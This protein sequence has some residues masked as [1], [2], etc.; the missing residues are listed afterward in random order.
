MSIYKVD[1]RTNRNRSH[2]FAFC[3]GKRAAH[4][5]LTTAWVKATDD[6]DPIS[7]E[8]SLITV[9]KVKPTEA[10]ILG[11]LNTY[12]S[13]SSNSTLDYETGN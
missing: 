6:P 10:G 7:L 3:K 8:N 12:A 2:S 5:A 4:V 9:V 1:I 13:H 11:A